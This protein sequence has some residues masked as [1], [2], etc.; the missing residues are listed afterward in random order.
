MRWHC[1][2]DGSLVFIEGF[3]VPLRSEAGELTGFLKI[4]QDVTERMQAHEH[5]RMLLA[6]LQHRV[7]NTLAV[8]RSIA[9]RTAQSSADVEEMSSHLQGRLAAL[10]RVQAVVTRNPGVGIELTSLVEDELLAHAAQEGPRLRIRGEE[11]RL[12]VKAAESLSLAVH[13]LTTNAV[14]YGALS[15]GTGRLEIGWRLE[16]DAGTEMLRFH[17]R[18]RN[19]GSPDRQGH[20]GFGTELLLRSLPYELDAETALDFAKDGIRFE[21]AIPADRVLAKEPA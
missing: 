3:A 19:S 2:K 4:G 18:E 6:E 20:E 17:W 14:K 12:Q 11:V 13:E 7:R 16:G 9:I 5:E 21:M 1:R 15:N 8:V 10:S